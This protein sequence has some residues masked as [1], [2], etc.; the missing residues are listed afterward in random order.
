MK[1]KL[2]ENPPFGLVSNLAALGHDVHTPQQEG[3]SGAMDSQLWEAAQ[4]DERFLDHFY[5]CCIPCSQG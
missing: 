1:I 4:G 5:V 3:L 2:D